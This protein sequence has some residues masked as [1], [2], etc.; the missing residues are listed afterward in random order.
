MRNE[1]CSTLV[2][3][4]DIMN[5]CLAGVDYTDPRSLVP[6][7]GVEQFDSSQIGLAS[8]SLAIPIQSDNIAEGTEY[9]ALN[10][11]VITNGDDLGI[12]PVEPTMAIVAINDT[13][14]E[15]SLPGVGVYSLPTSNIL[16]T[17]L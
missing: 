7:R 8:T 13:N 6:G 5:C 14:G 17:I 10:F 9:F 2:H 15:C 12:I 3:V 4:D 16:P 1:V 11:L